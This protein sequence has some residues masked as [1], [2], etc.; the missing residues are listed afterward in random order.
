MR[1]LVAVAALAALGA[2]A[3]ACATPP[4]PEPCLGA[5]PQ[6]VRLS[7]PVLEIVSHEVESDLELARFVFEPLAADAGGGGSVEV[8]ASFVEPAPAVDARTGEAVVVQGQRVIS[9]QIHGLAGGADTDRLRADPTAPHAIREIV[10]VE[11]ELGARWLIGV[12]DGVC[13]RLRANEDAGVVVVAVTA[14]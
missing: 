12:I 5:D 10:Q 3:G 4:P 9:V 2:A 7:R 6:T 14:D 1:C 11:S 8:T 13:A